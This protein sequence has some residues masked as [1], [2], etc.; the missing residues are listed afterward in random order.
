M[1]LFGVWILLKSACVQCRVGDFDVGLEEMSDNWQFDN[2]SAQGARSEAEEE[3]E[4]EIDA[5][6]ERAGVATNLAANEDNYSLENVALFMQTSQSSTIHDRGPELAVDGNRNTDFNEGSVTHTE[7]EDSPW[8]EVDLQEPR[9]ISLIGVLQRS[10]CC[11]QRRKHLKI[12]IYNG[13]NE[14]WSW[15]NGNTDAGN[16]V[17]VH[18]HEGVGNIVDERPGEGEIV[19][20][21]RVRVS[22]EQLDVQNLAEVEVFENVNYSPDGVLTNEN[23]EIIISSLDIMMKV[24]TLVGDTPEMEP[25]DE[26]ELVGLESPT[27]DNGD[28]ESWRAWYDGHDDVTIIGRKDNLCY[29]SFRSTQTGLDWKTNIYDRGEMNM[30]DG[31][32]GCVVAEGFYGGWRNNY[33]QGMIA[34]LQSCM[35]DYC[36]NEGGKYCIVLA[37][38]SQGAAIAQIAAVALSE[39]EPKLTVLLGA[40]RS[41]K[42]SCR[43]WTDTDRIIHFCNTKGVVGILK[44]DPICNSNIFDGYTDFGHQ[45][46]LPPLPTDTSLVYDGRMYGA[47]RRVLYDSWDLVNRV[48]ADAHTPREGSGFGYNDKLYEYARNPSAITISGFA[49]NIYCNNGPDCESGICYQ[50]ARLSREKSCRSGDI[51]SQCVSGGSDCKDDLYCVNARCSDGSRGSHCQSHGDCRGGNGR[52]SRRRVFCQGFSCTCK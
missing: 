49:N 31:K 43:A 33:Y 32:Q 27:E 6:S 4:A 38:Y 29:V 25:G 7:Q 22:N 9:R 3:F 47:R 16:E 5:V 51:G 13:G 48:A 42:A 17:R 11:Q 50:W 52:C 12:T 37:G 10:D 41:M 28:F 35:T 20:G 39:Y 24:D 46:V 21:T 36:R 40:P 15:F 45:F 23:W 26:Q 18:M 2:P 19:I 44:F 1:K 34:E 8:W 30:P 14:V